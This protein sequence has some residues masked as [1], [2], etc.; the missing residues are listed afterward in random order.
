MSSTNEKRKEDKKV[1]WIKKKKY[2]SENFS[3]FLVKKNFEWAELLVNVHDTE[4]WD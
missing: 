1:N 4:Q 3:L 2:W